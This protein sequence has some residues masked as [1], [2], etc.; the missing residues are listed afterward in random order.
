[1]VVKVNSEEFRTV[2][3]GAKLFCVVP[4]VTKTSAVEP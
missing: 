2:R 3:F 4:A 1:M